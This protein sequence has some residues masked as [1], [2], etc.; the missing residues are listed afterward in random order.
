MPTENSRMHKRKH[1]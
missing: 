1:R